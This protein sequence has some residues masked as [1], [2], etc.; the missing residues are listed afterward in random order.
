MSQ[1]VNG[2]FKSFKAAGAMSAFTRVKLTGSGAITVTNAGDEEAS[3]GILQEAALTAG[4]DVNVKMIAGCNTYK[5]TAAGAITKGNAIYPAA[6]GR[7]E[8]T[9]TTSCGFALDTATAAGDI[10]EAILTR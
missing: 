7:V 2:P 5:I 3:I 6:S 8:A 4:D 1:Q 9:G 10:I